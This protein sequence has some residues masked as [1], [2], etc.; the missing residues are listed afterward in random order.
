MPYIR[1][2]QGV[3]HMQVDVNFP[4]P[5]R[6]EARCKQLRMEIGPPP[7]QGGDP[8][9]YGPFDMLLCALATCTGYA[10]L[11]FLDQRGFS[12]ADAGLRIEAERNPDSHLLDKVSMEIRV[13]D[14]FPDKYKDAVVRATDRCFIK[15]QLGHKPDFEIRVI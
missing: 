8:E 3:S 5:D 13:P 14:G 1:S 15:A 4:S 12:T 9:A 2:K 10:V 11:A 6:V 7:D